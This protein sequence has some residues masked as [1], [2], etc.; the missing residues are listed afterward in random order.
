MGWG[1]G[2]HGRKGGNGVAVELVYDVL[3]KIKF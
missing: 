2:G 3:K 1:E